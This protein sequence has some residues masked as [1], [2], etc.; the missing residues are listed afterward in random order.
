[1]SL[2]AYLS[3]GAGV[4]SSALALMAAVGEIE[5]M[6]KAAIF[7]D[8]GWEPR[9]VYDYLE[10]LKGELPFPVHVVKHHGL[11][12][13][14]HVLKSKGMRDTKMHMPLPLFTLLPERTEVVTEESAQ[15]LLDETVDEFDESLPPEA[16]ITIPEQRG[17]TR[18]QCTRDWKIRPVERKVKE[19]MGHR[20]HA[21]LP[22]VPVLEQWIGISI[23]EAVRAKDSREPWKVHRFPLLDLRMHRESCREWIADHG[24]PEPPRSACIG[25]PYH[26]DEEW[27]R[28]RQDPEAWADAVD[29]DEQVRHAEG[30]RGEFYLHHSC[31]PLAEAVQEPKERPGYRQLWLGECEGMCGV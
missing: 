19:L 10:W 24:Y 6:P 18:R 12:L 8:T 22:T 17:M 11:P 26:S 25:C 2:P 3:L 28:I 30:L 23:D 13:R 4:Q 27:W 5:P 15:W 20:K 16:T 29:A 9:E 14:E 1:M 31:R 7:S 21:R